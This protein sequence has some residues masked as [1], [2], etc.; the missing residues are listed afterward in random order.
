MDPRARR[1][2][3]GALVSSASLV[4]SLPMPRAG[5]LTFYV[6]GPGPGES[7]AVALPDGS[8]MVVDACRQDGVDLP[9]ALLG[10]FGVRRVALAVLTHPDADHLRG[11]AELSRTIEPEFL[12][13][14]P[15]LMTRRRLV[16]HMAREH[17]D[18][19]RWSELS[20]ALAVIEA[21]MARNRAAPVYALASRNVGEVAIHCVA[22]SPADMER[23]S[24]LLDA[25]I[26][27]IAQGKRIADEDGRLIRG[28][29]VDGGGNGLSL[30]L[31][32][33]W[34]GRRFCLAGDVE[35][36]D[37]P[38]RGW[39]GACEY[40]DAQGRGD[41]LRDLS[42]LKLPHHGSI[43]ASSDE[44]LRRHAGSA[45][46]AAIATPFIGGKAPPP[47][48]SA[49]GELRSYAARLAITTEPACGWEAVAATGWAPDQA[50][51]DDGARCVVAI[52]RADGSLTVAPFGSARTFV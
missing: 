40:L 46:L 11:F 29:R 16:T 28:R 36:P 47:H 7:I 1:R 42:L 49:L 2:S 27:R 5:E 51:S 52:A 10:A 3:A 48:P 31:V 41:V 25:L 30:A 23:E 44:A 21:A 32:L 50:A 4:A 12:W 20:E 9:R 45:R 34:A 17:A 14:F 8:W 13:A 22:P 33:E 6:F 35:A 15:Q 39:R 19:A 37:D 18:D 26:V 43:S 38:H 24:A